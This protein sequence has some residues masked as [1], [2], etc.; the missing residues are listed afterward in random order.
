MDLRVSAFV[1]LVV[2]IASA[3]VHAQAAP[4]QPEQR[5]YLFG[6]FGIA[7]Q[8]GEAKDWGQTGRLRSPGG[9]ENQWWFGAGGFV[10]AW[11]GLEGTFQRT[12]RFEQVELTQYLGHG[13]YQIE[14]A[15]RRDTLVS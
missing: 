14:R 1:G 8:S 4:A 10:T 13:Q 12:G 2:C 3:T 5:V 11:L 9:R 6:G 7:W 15:E